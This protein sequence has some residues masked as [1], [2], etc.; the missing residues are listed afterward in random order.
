MSYD[1]WAEMETGNEPMSSEGINY[2]YNVSEM[3]TRASGKDRFIYDFLT[4]MT[5][6][7]AVPILRE[8]IQKM[9]D[10]PKEYKKLN[11]SNDWGDY[12]GCL[13]FLKKIKNICVNFPNAIIKSC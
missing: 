8:A 11:P 7:D 2:T 13:E 6:K 10:N 9:E 12:D 3:L 5:C 4:G 1:V